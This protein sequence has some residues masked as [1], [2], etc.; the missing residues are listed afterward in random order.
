[1]LSFR[2]IDV[3]NGEPFFHSWKKKS[4]LHGFT[5]QPIW[6]GISRHLWTDS[7]LKTFCAH[8]NTQNVDNEWKTIIRNEVLLNI[9]MVDR[10]QSLD[11]SVNDLKWIMF[12]YPKGWLYLDR[13]W[14]YRFYQRQTQISFLPGDF[15]RES[16]ALRVHYELRTIDDPFIA[17]FILP[18]MLATIEDVQ[19]T[20]TRNQILMRLVVAACAIE[21]Y[22]IKTGAMP[23]SL[24]ELVPG[25]LARIP[26]D[27]IPNQPLMY[28]LNP[29]GSFLIYSVGWN[30]RDEGGKPSPFRHGY[31]VYGL[32]DIEEGDWPWPGIY[33]PD[34]GNYLHKKD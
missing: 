23:K 24:E 33:S 27:V 6:E 4:Q 25:F 12:F 13:V 10:L 21:Q 3:L 8:F 29:D 17:T 18:K 14:L 19:L 22:R 30:R 31:H 2:L 28:R 15:T 11:D 9:D 16:N 32:A 5:L 7:Q 20:A 34:N 1:L 26:F